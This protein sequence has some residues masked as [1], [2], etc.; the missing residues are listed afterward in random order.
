[1]DAKQVKINDFLTSNNTIFAIPVYQ[2]NYD[3]KEKQCKQLFDD[4]MRVGE[5]DKSDSGCER[6]AIG[7]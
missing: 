1:M 3:W 6:R 4:I 2:R 5:N 7:Y